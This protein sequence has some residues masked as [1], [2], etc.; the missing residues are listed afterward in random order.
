MSQFGYG[1]PASTCS[2][3]STRPPSRRFR[4]TT[5]SEWVLAHLSYGVVR[6]ART[7]L[8]FVDTVEV[9]SPPEAR[10]ELAGAAAAIGAVYGGDRAPR[11]EVDPQ[12]TTG[13]AQRG[14]TWIWSSV[15]R[16][17]RTHP[18]FINRST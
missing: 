16:S 17:S 3:G 12:V 15:H 14:P 13:S 7:L 6:E 9:L 1:V 4:R 5:A 10:A 2:S 8:A 11:G 18:A